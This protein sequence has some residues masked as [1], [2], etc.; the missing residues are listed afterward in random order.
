[1]RCPRDGA[2]RAPR[3]GSTALRLR[4]LG[5]INSVHC[6]CRQ[7]TSNIR[8]RRCATATA[9]QVRCPRLRSSRSQGIR[10][11]PTP[12]EREYEQAWKEHLYVRTGPVSEQPQRAR[13]PARCGDP[14]CAHWGSRSPPPAQ[15]KRNPMSLV[16]ERTISK[17]GR[18]FSTWRRVLALT[19]PGGF[20]PRQV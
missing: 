14:R 20:A 1:M 12:E 4:L 10:L 8:G 18:S 2:L 6:C 9:Q 15:K 7:W 17:L 3:Y 13:T 11:S 16:E 19:S 5:H